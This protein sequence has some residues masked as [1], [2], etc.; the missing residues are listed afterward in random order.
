MDGLIKCSII[1]QRSCI[2]PSSLSDAIINSCVACVERAFSLPQV[3]DEDHA[4]NGTWVM[5][6]MRWTVEKGYWILELYEVYQ[7]QVTQYDPKTGEGGIFV[8]YINKFLKL[9]TEASGYPGWVHS[10]TDGD[11]YVDA[12]W[13]SEGIRLYKEAIRQNAAKRGLAKHCLKSKW[14]KLTEKNDRTMT[15][16]IKEPKDPKDFCP[17]LVSR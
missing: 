3:R 12:F 11:R 8:D 5:D 16:I 14:G 9:K 13:Q 10:P 7:Y 2:T 4:L 1:P 17:P 6:D 15:K